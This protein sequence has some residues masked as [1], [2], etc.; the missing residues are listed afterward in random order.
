[1][2][3]IAIIYLKILKNKFSFAITIR[4]TDTE[5]F[6]LL[7]LLLLFCF[8]FVFVFVFVCVCVLFFFCVGFCLVYVLFLLSIRMDLVLF[9]CPS[10]SQDIPRH[11]YLRGVKSLE[12]LGLA[13]RMPGIGGNAIG[14]HAIGG[15]AIGGHAIW[16][17]PK[18]GHPIGGHP[19]GGH[20]R[21]K[22][23]ISGAV[24]IYV[25]RQAEGPLSAVRWLHALVCFDRSLIGILV[26]RDL[27]HI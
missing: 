26:P 1:M 6:V 15:N 2:Q 18:G 16:G 23:I 4:E 24:V 22:Q 8:C 27:I 11:L 3:I 10:S 14:G 25:I 7:F 12:P 19:I 5:N 20:P 9:K 17:H 13:M 21:G